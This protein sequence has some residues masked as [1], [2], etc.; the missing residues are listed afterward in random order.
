MR[1]T[2]TINVP[3]SKDTVTNCLCP[4]CPVQQDSQCVKDKTRNM[5]AA[6]SSNS[7]NPSAI[8]A[9]Y[10]ATG[11]ATCQD[12]DTNQDCICPNCSVFNKYNLDNGTPV[13]YYC[14]D[15]KAH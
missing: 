12:I 15:G 6:L 7:L 10:C 3:F 8:P 2:A 1:Q 14:K 9:A 5:Q 4:S 13:M 11:K